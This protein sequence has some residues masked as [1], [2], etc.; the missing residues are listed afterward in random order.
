MKAFYTSSIAVSLAAALFLSA[1]SMTSPSEPPHHSLLTAKQ[2]QLYQHD[3]INIKT[4]WWTR[5]NDPQLNQLIKLGLTNNL[6]LQ[7]AQQR[8][9]LA[10]QQVALAQAGDKPSVNLNVSGGAI[11]A[12]LDSFSPHNAEYSAL[13][14]LLPSFS[15][16]FD[17]WGKNK[18]IIAAATNQKLSLEAQAVQA[19]LLLS[20]AMTSSYFTL[21]NNYRLE[22]D[23]ELLLR[24]TNKQKSVINDQ[25]KRGLATKAELFQQ[26]GDI[27]KLSAQ[28]SMTKTQQQ[29]AK[30]QLALYV[31]KTP[32]QLGTLLAP[33]AEPIKQLNNITTIP[34][35][36]LGRR[37]DIIANK[38]IV[39]ANRQGIKHAKAAYYPDMNLMV[40]GVF[41]KLSSM[42]PAD[43]FLSGATVATTLPL[44]DG[45]VR[46]A[47]YASA[48]IDYDQA[49]TVYN[50]S[51]LTAVKQ[52]Y[53]AIVNLQ[54]ALQQ[55][56]LSVASTTQYQ[57]AYMI[58]KH[59]Y[60][61]GLA[62]FSEMNNAQIK[63]HQQVIQTTNADNATLQ[64][65]LQLIVA[66]GGGYNS[67]Q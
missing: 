30:N 21:Q 62:S 44:Y 64:N 12:N 13:G 51:V 50:Q 25:I 11:G 43:L 65:Q 31:A 67:Q 66:L 19:K 4:D 41:Q 2:V 26:Q 48:N 57:Q 42:N 60:Q 15:Y 63:W 32:Q 38:W 36:L 54:E 18:A 16:Q 3:L 10:T 7:Q 52:A 34:I 61:R 40:M 53:D 37:A 9:E 17:F 22:R 23:I 56:A 1:C 47:N 5:F 58:F 55:Q 59:R 45:G 14:M 20:A 49:V 35:N 8:I 27:D 29:L 28:L 24:E 6:T 46:D 33:N 39:E